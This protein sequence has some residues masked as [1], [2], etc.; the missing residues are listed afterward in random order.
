MTEKSTCSCHT[1]SDESIRQKI[2]TANVLINRVKEALQSIKRKK[3]QPAKTVISEDTTET[4]YDIEEKDTHHRNQM[5]PNPSLS[6]TQSDSELERPKTRRQIIYDEKYI[7][8]K[9]RTEPKDLVTKYDS[10]LELLKSKLNTISESTESDDSKGLNHKEKSTHKEMG[11]WKSLI[12][13]CTLHY[14]YC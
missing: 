4:T 7:T 6:I 14:I 10:E 9:Y 11:K 13:F 12:I 3:Q 1:T 2:Q 8:E 5:V